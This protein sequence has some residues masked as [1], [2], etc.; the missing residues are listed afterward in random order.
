M[1]AQWLNNIPGI[2]FSLFAGPLSDKMGRKPLMLF[3][4]AGHMLWAVFGTINSAFLDRLPLEFFYLG[5][6]LRNSVSDENFYPDIT[7][8]ENWIQN[9]HI[10]F[11]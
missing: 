11:F 6:I 9:F 8:V 4:I 7:C 2:V 3:P 5:S 10:N 1:N